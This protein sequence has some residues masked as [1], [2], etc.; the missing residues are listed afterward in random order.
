MSVY[1]VACLDIAISR[2]LLYTM[3]Y[4]AK[5]YQFLPRVISTHM[6]YLEQIFYDIVLQPQSTKSKL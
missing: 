1:N 2:L 3:V 5:S 4:T 6:N